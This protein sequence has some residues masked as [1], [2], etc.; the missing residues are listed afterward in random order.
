MFLFKIKKIVLF[1]WKH[2]SLDCFYKGKN[3]TPTLSEQTLSEQTIT[4][5]TLKIECEFVTAEIQFSVSPLQYLATRL[6]TAWN[7]DCPQNNT[8]VYGRLSETLRKRWSLLLVS[9]MS[10]FTMIEYFFAGREPQF[11]NPIGQEFCFVFQ[12]SPTCRHH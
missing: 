3:E 2:F 12:G 6:S 8:V 10:L 9:P 4:T 11:S 7:K 1:H 5:F